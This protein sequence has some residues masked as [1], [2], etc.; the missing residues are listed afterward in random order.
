[1]DLNKNSN[2]IIGVNGGGTGGSEEKLL[3]SKE[4]IKKERDRIKETINQ[5][6]NNP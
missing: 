3:Q 2:S 5:Q 4:E 1:M 6:K